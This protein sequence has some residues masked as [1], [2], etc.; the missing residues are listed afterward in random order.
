MSDCF[1]HM[2]DA[3]DDALFG[4]TSQG[5]SGGSSPYIK[6]T[7]YCKYC[8]KPNLKWISSGGRWMLMEEG[9]IHICRTQENLIT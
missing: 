1:D 7:V 4:A 6:R 8:W 3:Y 9:Q 5:I 2:G